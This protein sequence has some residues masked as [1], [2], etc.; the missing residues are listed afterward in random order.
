MASGLTPPGSLLNCLSPFRTGMVGALCDDFVRIA[1]LQPVTQD[2]TFGTSPAPRAVPSP[3]HE[4]FAVRGTSR[5]VAAGWAPEGDLVVVA[6][7]DRV[8]RLCPLGRE[9]G[10]QPQP[11]LSL[12]WSGLTPSRLC[13]ILFDAKC[14]AVGP[15]DNSIDTPAAS[16]GTTSAPPAALVSTRLV[17]LAGT[18]GLQFMYGEQSAVPII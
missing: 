5:P 18:A 14:V 12:D 3:G 7:S 9:G 11:P 10:A 1:K 15:A 8:V 16:T 13:P 2:G 17:A 6:G 4:V